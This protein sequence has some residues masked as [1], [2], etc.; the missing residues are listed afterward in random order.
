[1]KD[2]CNHSPS[3]KKCIRKSD[4][5]IFSLPRKFSKEKCKKGIKGFTMRSSCAP[6]KDCLKNKKKTRNRR[7][8]KGGSSQKRK[9]NKK[10]D[11]RIVVFAG[12]CFWVQEDKFMKVKGVQ[13]TKKRKTK[14]RKNIENKIF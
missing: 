12:G 13:K 11:K 6:Y 5:K 2:C 7:K 1:M 4:K 3:D 14:K 9:S 8:K 10:K